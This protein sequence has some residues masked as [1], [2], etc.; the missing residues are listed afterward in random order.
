[1]SMPVAAK[2]IVGAVIA[3]L[4]IAGLAYS[5]PTLSNAAA[6]K[7]TVFAEAE[8]QKM[9]DNMKTLVPFVMGSTG[10]LIVGIALVS[11]GASEITSRHKQGDEAVDSRTE[12]SA[13][14]DKSNAA[15]AA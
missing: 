13:Q 6:N 1:M 2:L 3:F 15:G 12:P 4:G 10:V 5:L 14:R 9:P 11:L 7:H 8:L